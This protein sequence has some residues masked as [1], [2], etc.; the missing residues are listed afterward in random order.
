MHKKLYSYINGMEIGDD[1]ISFKMAIPEDFEAFD[2]HFPENPIL[3]GIMLLEIGN[4][5]LELF[6]E[7]AVV[8]KNIKKMKISGVVLPNQIISCNLKIDKS[9]DSLISFSAS[10]KGENDREISRYSGCFN[11]G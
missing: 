8:F 4:L 3:P 10:F 6:M 9:N 7:Q 2:G 11:K 1:F 5:A